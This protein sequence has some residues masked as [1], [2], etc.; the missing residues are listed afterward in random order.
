MI[1]RGWICGGDGWKT[2]KLVVVQEAMRAKDERELRCKMVSP[3]TICPP[4]FARLSC[5]V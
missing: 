3:M 1:D 2:A 4:A 5:Q